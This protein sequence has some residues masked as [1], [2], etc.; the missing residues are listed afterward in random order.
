MQ[1][2]CGLSYITC[3]VNTLD[4]STPSDVARLALFNASMDSEQYFTTDPPNVVFI[5]GYSISNPYTTST[6]L[7]P[8][9]EVDANAYD[10]REESSDHENAIVNVRRAVDITHQDH[11]N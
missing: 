3:I 6:V 7:L 11:S 1:R 10:G 4:T 9:A 8:L 2:H 5:L